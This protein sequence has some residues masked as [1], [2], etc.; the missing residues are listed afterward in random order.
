M[1]TF[2]QLHEGLKRCAGMLMDPDKYSRQ[3][4]YPIFRIGSTRIVSIRL[5]L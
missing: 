2:M 5:I 4:Y 3:Q 1:I